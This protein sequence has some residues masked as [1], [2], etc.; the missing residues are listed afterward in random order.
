MLFPAGIAL[1]DLKGTSY[2]FV[3]AIGSSIVVLAM[4]LFVVIVFRVTRA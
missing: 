1:V 4:A 3:P 2:I